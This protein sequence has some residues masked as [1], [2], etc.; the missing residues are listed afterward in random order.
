MSQPRILGSEEGAHPLLPV[1][2]M[3]RNTA[4]TMLAT[5]RAVRRACEPVDE[6]TAPLRGIK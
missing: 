5:A 2:I 6:T 3:I 1:N 4:V